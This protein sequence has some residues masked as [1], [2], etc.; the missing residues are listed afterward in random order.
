MLHMSSSKWQTRPALG[1]GPWRDLQTSV[2]HGNRGS[3][4]RTPQVTV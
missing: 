4:L 2:C 1:C 3:T